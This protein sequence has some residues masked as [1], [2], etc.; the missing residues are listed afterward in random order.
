MTV[1]CII[2]GEDLFHHILTLR[3][4]SHSYIYDAFAYEH[5]SLSSIV[6]LYLQKGNFKSFGILTQRLLHIPVK[7]CQII[8]HYGTPYGQYLKEALSLAQELNCHLHD[9]KLDFKRDVAIFYLEKS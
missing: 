1:P 2:I 3:F 4:I 8:P 5:H 9:L 6:C 7:N